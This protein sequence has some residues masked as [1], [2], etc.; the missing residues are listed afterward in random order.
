MEPVALSHFLVSQ[1][2]RQGLDA[3]TL[4]TRQSDWDWFL[5]SIDR[6]FTDL[7][8]I[9]VQSNRATVMVEEELSALKTT[10]KAQSEQLLGAQQTAQLAQQSLEIAGLGL[11]SMYK[12]QR[13]LSILAWLKCWS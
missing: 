4:P 8:A 9:E 7:S 10:F 3:S 11:F 13:C 12:K 5:Q 1:L 2:Q 6:A